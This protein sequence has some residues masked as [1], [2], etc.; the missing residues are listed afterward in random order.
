ML[1][2]SLRAS[3]EIVAPAAWRRIDFISDLHLAA[4]TPRGFEAWRS[5]L[6]TTGADAVF[7]LGDLFEAWVGDDARHQGFEAQGAQVLT[8]AA[9]RCK[10]FFM[11]G[12]RDFLLGD[13]MLAACGV[14]GLPDPTAL[15]AFGER[16]LLTHGDAW[17]TGDLLYQQFRTQVRNPLWQSQVLARPLAERRLMARSLRS[18]S[19]RAT[20]EHE[21]QWFDVDTPTALRAMTENDTP[22]LIHGHTHRPATEALAPGR[23]RHVLSDW[24]LDHE[25][26]PRAEVMRWEPGRWTRLAP[27]NAVDAAA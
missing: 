3:R 12:N 2:K 26:A 10:L 27:G 4:D 25:L 14:E 15:S 18:E 20:A 16:V 8:A 5:Y 1:V 19:E 9:A 17:C 21:G 24:E 6:L 23:V 7:I 13:E 11:V 22:T